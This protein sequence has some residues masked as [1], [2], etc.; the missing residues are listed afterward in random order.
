MAGEAGAGFGSEPRRSSNGV[1]SYEATR[2]CK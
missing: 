1:G 2:C